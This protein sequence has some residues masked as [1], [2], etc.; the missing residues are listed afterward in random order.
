MLH[1]ALVNMSNGLLELHLRS[2][3]IARS[4]ARS[5]ARSSFARS[6]DHSVDPALGRSIERSL[7]RSVAR[8][9]DCSIARSLARSIARS[10]DRS[11]AR[12]LGRS[13]ARSIAGSLGQNYVAGSKFELQTC[14][15]I[16]YGVRTS[17][18]QLAPYSCRKYP[19][20]ELFIVGTTTE[21]CYCLKEYRA[22]M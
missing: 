8:S 21:H 9:L 10:L 19:N 13:I 20:Y 4:L 14:S 3:S 22:Y 5:F 17:N 18:C 15:I 2:P 12:S 6:L 1:N 11:I 16:I 7:H